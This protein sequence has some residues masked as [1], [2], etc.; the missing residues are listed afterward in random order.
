MISGGLTA[1]YNRLVPQFQH[2]TENKAVTASGNHHQRHSR[3][4][5]ARP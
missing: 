4:A 3:E 2:A 5:C 1:A